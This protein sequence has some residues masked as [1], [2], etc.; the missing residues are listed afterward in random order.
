MEILAE[1]QVQSVPSTGI[2]YFQLSDNWSREVGMVNM[3]MIMM[4]LMISA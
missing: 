3:M 1:M 4:I 2:E